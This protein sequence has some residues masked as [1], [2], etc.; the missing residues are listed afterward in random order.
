MIP[1]IFLTYLFIVNIATYIVYAVDKHKAQYDQWRIPEA[2]LLG[3]SA[4]GG[5]YG[6]GAAMLLLRHKTRHTNFLVIVPL[7]LAIWIVAT[8]YVCISTSNT[9]YFPQ[10]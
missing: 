5:A 1:T 6:A 2:V 9:V 10:L 4:I 7:T 3:L 8:V